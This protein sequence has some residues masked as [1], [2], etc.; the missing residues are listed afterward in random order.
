[1]KGQ[2]AGF[3]KKFFFAKK[4][5]RAKE[6]MGLIQS[7]SFPIEARRT[8]RMLTLRGKGKIWPQVKVAWRPKWVV[9]QSI[10]ASRRKKHFV[11]ILKAVS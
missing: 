7:Q 8:K 6:A 3:Y 1:M 9:L 4:K 10:D 11:T 2:K 5:L